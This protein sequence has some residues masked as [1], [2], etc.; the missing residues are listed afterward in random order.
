VDVRALR[1]GDQLLLPLPRELPVEFR[2]DVHDVIDG[3]GSAPARHR[4][5]LP[6]FA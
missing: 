1:P 6:I 5:R 2:M 3:T 4:A